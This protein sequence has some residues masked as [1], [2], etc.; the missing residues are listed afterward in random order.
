MVER[1][2]KTEKKHGSEKEAHKDTNLDYRN[3]RES[4]GKQ[5]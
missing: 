1:E 3:R 5:S 4:G 2:K